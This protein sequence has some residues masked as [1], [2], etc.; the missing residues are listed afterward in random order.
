MSI[1][2]E[3]LPTDAGKIGGTPGRMFRDLGD[4]G[5]AAENTRNN[6]I[7]H[8]VKGIVP[9]S[10]DSQY[11]I[12]Y[13][14]DVGRLVDHHGTGGPHALP[15]PLFSIGVD[16]AYLFA[17]GHDLAEEGIDLRFAR[18]AGG[19]AT[20]VLDVIADVGLDGA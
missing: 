2:P 19:C 7:E 16:A 5:I 15:E 6:V 17:G 8:V 12:G 20:D 9:G 11:A 4:D 13:V 1:D 3:G 18:I 14:F 10:N